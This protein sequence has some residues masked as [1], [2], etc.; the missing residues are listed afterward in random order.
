MRAIGSVIGTRRDQLNR[1]L[2]LAPQKKNYWL[3][4]SSVYSQMEDYEEA[5]ATVEIPYVAGML[6]QAVEIRRYADLLAFN[7]LGYRCGTVLEKGVADG[8]V[9]NNLST[10][11]TDRIDNSLVHQAT[12]IYIPVSG[13][14]IAMRGRTAPRETTRGTD[15]SPRKRCP[16][17]QV[18][19]LPEPISEVPQGPIWGHAN[20]VGYPS[21]SLR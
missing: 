4:L 19:R 10:D 5:L 6:N 11:Q 12:G 3:Q 13:W 1:I 9:E 14:L 20:E 17:A 2:A 8:I 16:E 21:A 18:A 15:A 7:G